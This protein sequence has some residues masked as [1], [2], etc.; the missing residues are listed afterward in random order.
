M[1]LQHDSA[2]VVTPE[3]I[4]ICMLEINKEISEAIKKFPGFPV[5][6][7]H[8]VAI[9]AEESGEAVQAALQY[10]YDNKPVENIEKEL[11]QTAAMCVR[12]L[13]HLTYKH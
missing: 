13:A 7:V 1:P 3:V 5:D 10:A 6:P 9:M 11:I 8:M 12:C 4:N 2:K